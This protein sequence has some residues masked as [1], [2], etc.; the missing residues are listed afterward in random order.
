MLGIMVARTVRRN[1]N[2]TRITSTIEIISVL[3]MSFTEARTDDRAVH[4]DRELDRR[5]KSR[6]A[7]Y[8]IIACTRSTVSMMFAPGCRKIDD[9]DAR[10]AVGQTNV[11]HIGDRILYLGHISQPHGRA[12]VVGH[13][14]RPVLI[15]G[16]KLIGIGEGV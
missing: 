13:D 3:S 7:R 9:E 15:G 5:A 11:A 6:T 4:H 12:I 10:F 16:E 8:G 1:T 14:Q 2:T